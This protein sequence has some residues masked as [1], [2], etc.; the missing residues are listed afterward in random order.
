MRT[1]KQAMLWALAVACTG[2]LIYL[3]RCPHRRYS[4]P[5]TVMTKGHVAGPIGTTYV[6]CLDCGRELK[7]DWHNL[8][9]VA[10]KPPCNGS[11][12]TPSGSSVSSA[13]A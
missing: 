7:Y 8:G 3:F 11:S 2:G 6:S 12:T 1:T 10:E 4:F 9:R 5:R 13:P